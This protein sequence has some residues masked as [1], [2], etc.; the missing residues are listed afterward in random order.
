MESVG[1]SNKWVGRRRKLMAL[2][3]T[4]SNVLL[5]FMGCFVIELVWENSR[6]QT[7]PTCFSWNGPLNPPVKGLSS[8]RRNKTFVSTD[9]VHLCIGI[10]KCRSVA[11]PTSTNLSYSALIQ[12]APLSRNHTVH[13]HN[14]SHWVWFNCLT[15]EIGLACLREKSQI[16]LTVIPFPHEFLIF[17]RILPKQCFS[18]WEMVFS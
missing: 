17:P 11:R 8:T 2:R 18:T 16:S 10:H 5:C 14:P 15:I 3:L 9:K 1:F 7:F 12:W 4:T 6:S 13:H